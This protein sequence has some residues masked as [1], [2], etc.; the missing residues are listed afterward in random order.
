MR[1][2]AVGLTWSST[3]RPGP[4]LTMPRRLRNR[5]SRSTP[6]PRTAYGRTKLSGERAV[7][8]RL[9]GSAYVVRTAWLYGAHGP[10]FVRTMIKLADQRPTVDVVDDQHGQPTWT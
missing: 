8:D 5:R 1:S 9:P 6:A 3:A 7:L 4:P 10:I 2:P